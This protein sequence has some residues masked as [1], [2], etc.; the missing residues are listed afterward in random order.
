MN[1]IVAKLEYAEVWEW[2]AKVVTQKETV[3]M[4]AVKTH[5]DAHVRRVI[6]HEEH[7]WECTHKKQMRRD[8]VEI[9]RYWE[10]HVKNEVA[11]DSCLTSIGGNNKRAR[12]N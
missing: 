9:T 12:W 10:E 7:N 4:T 3:Q 11:S 8:I 2:N 5:L 1:V 6:Q